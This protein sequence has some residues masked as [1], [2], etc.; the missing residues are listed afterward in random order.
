VFATS[1]IWGVHIQELTGIWLV[2]NNPVRSTHPPVYAWALIYFTGDHD[3]SLCDWASHGRS[4]DRRP[5][6]PSVEKPDRLREVGWLR[7]FLSGR[8]GAHAFSSSNSIV[9]SLIVYILNTGVLVW[10]VYSSVL[11]RPS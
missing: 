1:I 4:H 11:I 6:L 8:A 10:L 5:V 7:T 9:R 2:R 3:R